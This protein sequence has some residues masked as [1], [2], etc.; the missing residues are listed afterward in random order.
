[1]LLNVFTTHRSLK[2][3][4]L[5][6]RPPPPN[7]NFPTTNTKLSSDFF[8]PPLPDRDKFPIIVVFF[9]KASLSQTLGLSGTVGQWDSDLGLTT[10]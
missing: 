9:W 6:N 1:M 5:I 8:Y 7:I 4:W 10:T 2:I 3:R